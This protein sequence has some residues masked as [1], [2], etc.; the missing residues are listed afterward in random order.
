MAKFVPVADVDEVP[1]DQGLTVAV[2]QREIGI[3]KIDGR[4]WAIDNVCP[5]AGGPL[6]EGQLKG[7]VIQC[8]WH[9]WTF[10]VT[11]GVCTFHGDLKADCFEV[12]LQE[13]Q[14]WIRL[15]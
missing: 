8:P 13:G 2:G 11:T 9:A 12:R 15:D 5:H 4:I 1:S 14:V 10:E 6:A 3:F 7:S